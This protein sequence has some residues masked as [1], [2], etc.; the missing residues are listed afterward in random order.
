MLDLN[1]TQQP[2]L[3]YYTTYGYRFHSNLRQG[4]VTSTSRHSFPVIEFYM[5][6]QRNRIWKSLFTLRAL[7]H[8]YNNKRVDRNCTRTWIL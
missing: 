4:T 8:K 6:Y 3:E 1:I 2:S 5:T 7:L